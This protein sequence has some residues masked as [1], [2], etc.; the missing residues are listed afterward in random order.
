MRPR[1]MTLDGEETLLPT[2][3]V[4]VL[5]LLKESMAGNH[6]ARRVLLKYQEFAKRGTRRGLEIR[7]ADNDYMR[8]PPPSGGENG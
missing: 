4:I 3:K 8:K 1:L 2:I 5:Q 7:F 6:R